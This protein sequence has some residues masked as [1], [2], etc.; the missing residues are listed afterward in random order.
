MTRDHGLP[1]PHRTAVEAAVEMPFHSLALV[2][3]ALLGAILL[4]IEL[5]VSWI[6]PAVKPVLEP[7]PLTDQSVLDPLRRLHHH[8]LAHCG[9]SNLLYD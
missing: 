6:A 2:I 4:A 3:T 9:P 8:S 5:I 7:V 1:T